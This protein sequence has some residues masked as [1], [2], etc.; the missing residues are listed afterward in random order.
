MALVGAVLIVPRLLY[1]IWLPER[2]L[3]T[4]LRSWSQVAVILLQ[5]GNPYRDT[6]LL[7]WPPFWMQ[8]LFCL[9]H[10][11]LWLGIRFSVLVRVSLIAAECGLM[12]CL[13][14]LARRHFPDAA[15]PGW[16]VLGIALNPVCILLSVQHGNFDVIVAVWVVLFL[17]F[18][19]RDLQLRRSTGADENADHW[20]LAC[21]FLGLGIL[22]KV[23][24]VVLVPLLFVGCRQRRVPRGCTRISAP[25]AWR[26]GRVSAGLPRASCPAAG[27]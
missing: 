18:L 25:G 1:L 17:H 2:A 3:S 24:P 16:L 15:R 12:A 7:N 26:R 8:W 4:D 23:V 13:C 27:S 9:G 19:L 6:R 21:L 10:A 22:T 20:L 11:S 5:D 14:L